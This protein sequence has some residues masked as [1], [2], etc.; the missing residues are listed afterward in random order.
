MGPFSTMFS[1]Q[2]SKRSRMTAMMVRSMTS[3]PEQPFVEISSGEHNDLADRLVAAERRTD[4]PH[5]ES[6]RSASAIGSRQRM[7]FHKRR[8][9]RGDTLG[10]P[11]LPRL[12]R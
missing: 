5:D 11:R 8:L 4:S 3:F 6:T 2:E 7:T 12:S 9:P 10:C 1:E